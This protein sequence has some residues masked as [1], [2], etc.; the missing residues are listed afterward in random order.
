MNDNKEDDDLIVNRK[1]GFGL[2]HLFKKQMC[3][4]CGGTGTI[5]NTANKEICIRCDGN[6]YTYLLNK[7]GDVKM[8][9]QT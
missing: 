2:S 5:P 4:D 8:D 3:I 1:S 6:G 7:T 9:I